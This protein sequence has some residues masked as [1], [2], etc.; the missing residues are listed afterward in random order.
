LVIV[1][2]DVLAVLGSLGGIIAFV[3]AVIVVVRGIFRQV[4]AT[5]DLT[6]AVR[7]LRDTLTA[8]DRRLN[9]YG[10]RIARLEGRP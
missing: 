6:R 2:N 4:Q 9:D 1:G 3:T 10:E 8:Q 7:E 5:D